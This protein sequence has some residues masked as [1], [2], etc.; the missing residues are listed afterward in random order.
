[1]VKVAGGEWGGASAGMCM[2]CGGHASASGKTSE[3]SRWSDL[4]R[5][6]GYFLGAP[7]GW[8]TSSIEEKAG[9]WWAS[10]ANIYLTSGVLCVILNTSHHAN[11]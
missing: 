10:A 11:D 6:M 3:T 9:K 5:P 8:W 1:M 7:P 2:V 4:S